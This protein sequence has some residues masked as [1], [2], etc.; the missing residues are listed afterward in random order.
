M[1]SKSFLIMSKTILILKYTFVFIFVLFLCTSCAS[2][3]KNKV[4][5]KTKKSSC[6]LAQLVGPDT[7]YYSDHYKRKLKR[8]T[9]KL[10][11]K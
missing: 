3:K 6:S 11:R 8:A 7:Y 4:G 9:N 2:V 10:G 1:R 5:F